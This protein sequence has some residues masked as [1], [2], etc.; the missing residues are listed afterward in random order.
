MAPVRDVERVALVD[1]GPAIAPVAGD[2]GP[3]GEHVDLRQGLGCSGEGRRLLEHGADQRLEDVP[4]AHERVVLGVQNIPLLLPERLGHVALAPDRRLPADVV[5]RHQVQVGFGHLDIV[6]EV[7]RIPDFQAPYAGA[8]LF[9]AFQVGKPRLVAAHEGAKPVEFA[10]VARPDEIPLG[11]IGRWLVDERTRKQVAKV[12]Q[13]LHALSQG[14]R[15]GAKP[16]QRRADLGKALKRIAHAAQLAGVAQP[17]L[18]PAEDARDVPDAAKRCY[19]LGEARW[20]RDEFPDKRVAPANLGEIEAGSPRPWW[21]SPLP[22]RATPGGRRGPTRRSPG[23]E[24][25]PGPAG[26]CARFDTPG[27]CAGSP[28]LRA[29]CPWRSR[30]GHPPAPVP[31]GR[32]L[33]RTPRG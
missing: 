13:L 16:A 30:R 2:R 5:G 6:S 7:I 12:R 1:L 10:I 19:Q 32:S 8:L 18:E 25:S 33:A 3:T 20:L 23:C 31:D 27:G 17:V 14:G 11:D 9:A 28:A 26:A 15:M 22:R 4:L 29:G 24:A 21:W